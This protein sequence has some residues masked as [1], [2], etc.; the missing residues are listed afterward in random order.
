V[1]EAFHA[2]RYRKEAAAW[3]A[4]GRLSMSIR[5]DHLL[6]LLDA[7]TVSARPSQLQQQIDELRREILDLRS[8]LANE[9]L[10]ANRAYADGHAKG[11]LENIEEVR[12]LRA[13][14]AT[15]VSRNQSQ[16]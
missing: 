14:A 4:E 6:K 7:T 10:R 12:R 5:P 16:S 2:K 8:K 11:V 13:A 3:A 1:I 15:S 9:T